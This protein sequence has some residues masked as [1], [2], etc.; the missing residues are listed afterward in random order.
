M[1]QKGPLSQIK[2]T[3]MKL[4]EKIKIKTKDKFI[5]SHFWLKRAVKGGGGGGRNQLERES[6]TSL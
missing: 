4:S 1:C 6:T 3:M 2:G 5:F